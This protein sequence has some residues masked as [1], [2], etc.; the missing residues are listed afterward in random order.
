[1]HL[2]KS[3]YSL[4]EAAE[5]AKCKPTD[6]LHYAVQRKISLLVGVP[7]W[8]DVRVYD[9]TTNSD[10][11]P[12]L[13]TPQ[14]LVLAQSHCLKIEINGRTE[15]SDFPEGYFI[16]STGELKRILPSYGRADLNHRWVHWRTYR[17]QRAYPLE[18]VP[19]RLFVLHTDLSKLIE[20][21]A[22]P[23]H[24]GKTESKKHKSESPD[25]KS[26]D[27]QQSSPGTRGDVPL[28][29]EP[30][31]NDALDKKQPKVQPEESSV[32]SEKSSTILRIKQVQQ[33]TGLSRSTIYDKMNPKLPL[34]RFDP[35]FPKQVKLGVG[36]VG[37][38]ESEIITWIKSRK[39]TEIS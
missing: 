37:W 12:F 29:S 35:T 6:L 19:D 13:M 36:S 16:G 34:P 21:V 1:M 27:K 11:D 4:V 38:Y 10:V 7:D 14:L 23:E 30:D 28:P 26:H 2:N 8:A 25:L 39:D 9:E 33:R 17:D 15:Q 3:H 32:Q 24:S 18:L 22:N 5:L 31:T 20:P